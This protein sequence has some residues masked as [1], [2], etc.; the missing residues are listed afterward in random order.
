MSIQELPIRNGNAN[1]HMF[2]MEEA[3]EVTEL[4]AK[5]NRELRE[6]DRTIDNL[7]DK[8]DAA[9]VKRRQVGYERDRVSEY[10]INGISHAVDKETREV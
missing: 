8:L 4:L 6:H 1:P 7:Q 9:K 2:T 5:V 3:P 10:L